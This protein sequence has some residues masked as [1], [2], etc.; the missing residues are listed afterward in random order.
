MP[1]IVTLTLTR[2]LNRHPGLDPGFN[3]A[4]DPDQVV[5]HGGRAEAT[6]TAETTQLVV[7]PQPAG[8]PVTADALLEAMGCG[9]EPGGPTPEHLSSRLASGQLQVVSATCA[10]D[11]V[12]QPPKPW[13]ERCSA[14]CNI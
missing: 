1:C 9:D 6:V 10:A 2:I 7:L 12:P 13:A 8:A 11:R 3:L 14:A 4:P 5:R